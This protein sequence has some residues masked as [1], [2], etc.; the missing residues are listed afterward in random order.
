MYPAQLTLPT[1]FVAAVSTHG[2]GL[3]PGLDVR[4]GKSRVFHNPLFLQKHRS[5][6]AP[7]QHPCRRHLSGDV[8]AAN[9][10]LEHLAMN[11]LE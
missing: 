8:E 7:P 3:K 1:F 4:V 11:S 10:R 6:G 9:T 2:S 5:S